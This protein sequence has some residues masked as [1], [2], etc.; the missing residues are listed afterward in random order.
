MRPAGPAMLALVVAV[1]L[2]SKSIVTES[3]DGADAAS[4][5]GCAA[6]ATPLPTI[7]KAPTPSQI[8]VFFCITHLAAARQYRVRAGGKV[9]MASSAGVKRTCRGLQMNIR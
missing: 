1:M 9:T 6:T 3:S 7:A 8:L 5:G 2:E 4:C